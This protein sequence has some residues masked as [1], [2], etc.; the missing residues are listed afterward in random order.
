[1]SETFFKNPRETWDAAK[2]LKASRS[3][4]CDGMG[5]PYPFK[6]AFPYQKNGPKRYNG[7]TTR[8]GKWYNGETF[9]LPKLAKGF[10]WIYAP[11]WCWQIVEISKY[12]KALA[13]KKAYEKLK[14]AIKATKE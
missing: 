4:A 14:K 3:L 5:T 1:M 12:K 9:S 10:K 8:N 6:G 7:G 2:C 13:V 11:T